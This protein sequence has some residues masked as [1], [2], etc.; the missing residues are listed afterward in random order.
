MRVL[1]RSEV[2]P[3]MFAAVSNTIISFIPVFA[4]TGAEGKL[5][6]PLA[7]TKTFAIAASMVLGV[8]LVPVLAYLLLKPLRWSSQKAL[9]LA[10]VNG[11]SEERRGGKEVGSKVRIRW[12]P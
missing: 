3:A 12:S 7:F 8:T 11:R 1:F 2:G 4:L 5:F 10:L 6:K 9:L